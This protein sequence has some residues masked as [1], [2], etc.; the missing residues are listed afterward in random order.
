M[1]VELHVS[2]FHLNQIALVLMR[3]DLPPEVSL[4]FTI[5]VSCLRPRIVIHRRKR[6]GPKLPTSSN[7]VSVIDGL[8]SGAGRQ[9]AA[10][11]TYSMCHAA[12]GM[13][14]IRKVSISLGGSVSPIFESQ[15]MFKGRTILTRG[16]RS[17]SLPNL[18]R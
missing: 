8:K 2:S 12:H 9:T 7:Q 4:G 13:Y 16:R 3:S 1:C 6:D 5:M 15:R 11:R 10:D 17:S 14:N 18:F